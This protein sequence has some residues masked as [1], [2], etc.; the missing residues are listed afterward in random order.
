MTML[1]WVGWL[2]LFWVGFAAFFAVLLIARVSLGRAVERARFRRWLDEHP[3]VP[4]EW[5]DQIHG[6]GHG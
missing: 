6:G 2:L 1:A 4:G 3:G 5:W